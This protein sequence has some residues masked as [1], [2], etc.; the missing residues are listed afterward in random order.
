L[1]NRGEC[2][3]ILLVDDEPSVVEFIKIGLE[4]RG[5]LVIEAKLPANPGSAPPWGPCNQFDHYGLYDARNE[6]AGNFS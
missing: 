4:K 2:E 1:F 6:R 3:N 5:Y